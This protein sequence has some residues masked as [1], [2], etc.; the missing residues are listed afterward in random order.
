MKLK[1]VICAIAAGSLG[2][3]SLSFA[4]G[5]EPRGQMGRDGH[6]SDQRGFVRHD[7]RYGPN[8][9]NVGPRG[10]DHRDE[11]R[12]SYYGA[13]GPQYY[14]GGHIPAHYR[15]RQYVVTNWR[16]HHLHA[17]HRGQ[18]WI[19]VGSDYVLIAVATGVI[20]Q[21]VLSR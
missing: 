4:Q 20:A 14:R 15:N 10:F 8:G 3:A 17:P 7:G 16:A 9:P 21:L 6:H 19:Q 18:Q 1:A 2:F 12:D 5:Y 13:R 11:R